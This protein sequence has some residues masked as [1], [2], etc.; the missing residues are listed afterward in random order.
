MRSSTP[1]LGT[2]LKRASGAFLAALIL[3]FLPVT[4]LSADA[5]ALPAEAPVDIPVGQQIVDN[6]GVLGNSRGEVQNAID[7][8]RRDTGQ[9]LYVVFVDSFSGED[10]VSWGRT[11][12]E[13]KQAGASEVL[14]AVATEDRRRAL[15]VAERSQLSQSQQANIRAAADSQ[16]SQDNWSQT[17]IDTAAA[18]GDAAGG[19]SGTVPNPTGGIVGT[20]LFVLLVAGAIV[21]FVVVRR[22]RRQQAEL[23]S[24]SGIGP[25]GEQLDALAGTSI[26]ELRTRA[27]ALLIA[28]DDAIRSSE[29][30][31]GFAQAAYGDESVKPFREALTKAKEHLNASFALQQQLDDDI[32]DTMEQQRS[33]YSEIIQRTESANQ[34]LAEQKQSFDALRELES[35]APQALERVAAGAREAQ[36]KLAVA[37]EALTQLRGRYAESAFLSVQDNVEQA[38]QRLE[39]VDTATATAQSKL[40][41]QDPS[42]AAVAVRAAEE[43]LHQANLLEDAV[44]RLADELRKAEAALPGA[45]SSAEGDLVQAK[46]LVSSSPGHPALGPVAAAEASLQQARQQTQSAN[47][48]PAAVLNQVES[49]H[50]DLD[51]ALNTIRDQQQQAQRAQAALQQA[52]VSA[53]GQISASQDYIAARRGGVGAQ[54]RTRLAEA[55]RNLD[56][57]LSIQSSDPVSAL[58]YANQ[59]IALAQQAEGL[60]QS[61]IQGFGYVGSTMGSYGMGGYGRSGAGASFGGGLGGAILG[62]ILGG[63]ISGGGHRSD[64]WGG[65][66]FGGWGSGNS[67]GFGGDAGGWGGD[68]GNF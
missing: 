4:T 22:R 14:L 3:L 58:A 55:E 26:D 1:A 25:G 45:L 64:T 66:G 56:Y 11:A 46:A 32:P 30:E 65:G 9:T 39:F 49:A 59:A 44:S 40:Q 57:A 16:L 29:Q 15:I 47:Y 63:M 12:M 17:A 36:R 50:N 60:A 34:V 31:I 5:Y 8:L 20:L 23:D 62:G 61:D 52:L 35:Q 42:G 6:A 38:T 24:A 54:A 18:L 53:Q 33:W 67:G 27:G 51:T 48:D 19:G 43:S 41:A 2:L 13:N 7:S 21:A 68:V 28:A 10:P 37:Q